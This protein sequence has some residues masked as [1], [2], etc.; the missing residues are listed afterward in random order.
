[1][2]PSIIPYSD[3][4]ILVNFDQKID[5]LINQ[6]VHLLKSKLEKNEFI[7]Y[8][9]PAYCSLTIGY[10]P[11]R[12][13]YQTLRDIILKDIEESDHNLDYTSLTKNYVEIPVCYDLKFGIDLKYLSDILK[14][15]IQ[16][17]IDIHAL[18]EYYVYMIGFLPGFPYM[19]PLDKRL[20]TKRRNNPRIQVPSNSVAIAG[21]QTGI[22]P[23]CAPGGWH[24][25][26]RTPT[27][28]FNL[29]KKVATIQAGQWV[30]IKRIDVE[31][32][33]SI[34]DKTQQNND[35]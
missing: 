2:L 8:L 28:L 26:G 21:N 6:R 17:I 29:E 13:K 15:S 24:I 4:A 22:Y 14:L 3:Q 32:Y 31:E 12:C 16:D 23:R 34:L 35:G 7:T 9:I 1:M 33:N 20:R 19:G 30:K 18:Q 5:I 11:I 10:D 27:P 25:I